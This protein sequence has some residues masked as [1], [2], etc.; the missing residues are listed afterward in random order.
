MHEYVIMCLYKQHSEYALGPKCAKI[1]TTVL[2]MQAL[3]SVLMQELHRVLN[4]PQYG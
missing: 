2:N 3:H 4:I 1:L